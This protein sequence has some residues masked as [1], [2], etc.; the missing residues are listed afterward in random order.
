MTTSISET[1]WLRQMQSSEH[2]VYGNHPE[3]HGALNVRNPEPGVVYYWAR[4]KPGQVQRLQNL[5]YRLVDPQQGDQEKFGADM[6][7]SV[8]DAL[9]GAPYKD[10]ILMKITVEQYAELKERQRADAEAALHSSDEAFLSRGLDVGEQLRTANPR[11]VPV[12]YADPSHGIKRE[13]PDGAPR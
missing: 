8:A 13:G 7:E 3:P 12:Y 11:G 1:P 6:P 9:G 5:G 10:V 2:D 4:K